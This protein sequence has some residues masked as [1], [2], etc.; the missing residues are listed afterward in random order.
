MYNAFKSLWYYITSL[1][2]SN[3]SASQDR[4]NAAAELWSPDSVTNQCTTTATAVAAVALASTIAAPLIVTGMLEAFLFYALD[5]IVEEGVQRKDQNGGWWAWMRM[6]IFPEEPRAW[7][8]AE[9]DEIEMDITDA[10]R[11][12]ITRNLV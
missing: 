12:P 7:S 9:F 2:T 11:C 10:L 4:K 5:S 3:P 8:S 1:F 6:Y